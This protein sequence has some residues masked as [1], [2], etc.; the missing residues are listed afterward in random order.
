[1]SK[2]LIKKALGLC[3]GALIARQVTRRRPRILMYHGL[4]HD[5]DIRDWT[6]VHV[7]DFHAQMDYLKSAY[8]PI[9]LEKL[10]DSL[11]TGDIP[12]RAVAVTFD[13]GYKSNYELALPILRE[14]GIPATIF[15]TSGFVSGD[16][17]PPAPMWPDLVTMM[18]LSIPEDDLDLTRF[19][20]GRFVLTNPNN[21]R[22][23]R[24]R[25][26]E[27]LK[28]IP[29][30]RKNEIVDWMRDTYGGRIAYDRFSHLRPLNP[31]ELRRLADD[32]LI[33]IGAHTRSHPILSRL[34]ANDLAEE[35]IGGKIDLERMIDRE[36]F[37]F[38][39]P[40]GRSKDIG[41]E[42]VEMAARHYRSA[43]TT[44]EALNRP[45]TNKYLLPRIGVGRSL[46]L[47]EFKMR[48]AGIYHLFRKTSARIPAQV[49]PP[50]D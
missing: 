16:D 32:D 34:D 19:D 41:R 46:T 28:T 17:S 26:V 11:E 22:T 25:L 7:D 27:Y 1:M 47:P 3:G 42:A 23:S 4:T 43:V 49:P 48:M 5:R 21:R 20:I 50:G 38:A 10:V 12:P 8:H 6:Q 18:C 9:S 29:N 35:I 31:E 45:G 39:Y 44:E 40:N 36:V 13:D 2:R 33:T 14:V 24:N 30:R 37:H 15:V